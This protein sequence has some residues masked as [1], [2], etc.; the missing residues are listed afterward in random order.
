MLNIYLMT[1][2]SIF[3]MVS[4]AL[5]KRESWEACSVEEILPHLLTSAPEVTNSITLP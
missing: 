1:K 2:L 5:L 4:Q 3:L